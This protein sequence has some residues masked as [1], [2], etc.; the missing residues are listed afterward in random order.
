MRHPR[1]AFRQ[2]NEY[3]SAKLFQFLRLH[4]RVRVADTPELL[5]IAQVARRNI[6]EPVALCYKMLLE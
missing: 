4:D 1:N 3:A 5:W 2:S 6:I